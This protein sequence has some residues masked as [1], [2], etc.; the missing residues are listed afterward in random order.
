MKLQS[1]RFAELGFAHGFSL[2][3]GGVSRGPFDS[4]NLGRSV[5]DEEEAVLENLGRYADAVGYDPADLF[6][7][8]QVHG[9]EVVRVTDE[10]GRRDVRTIEADALVTRDPRL[11]I[12]VR[13][14]DCVPVLFGD[15]KSGVVGAA[16]AGWRGVVGGVLP[17]TIAAMQ[18]L[19]AEPGRLVAVIGPHIRVERFEIG[20]EV[21]EA[22]A[23]VSPERDPI[24]RSRE[25][26]HASLALAIRAQLEA[27]GVHAARIED[28]GGCS[29]DDAERFYS[30]RRDHGR[31]GRHLAVIVGP[32]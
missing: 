22:L 2:R 20:D 18:E 8:T 21:A 24:D 12:G 32:G 15:P 26:P 7:V 4:L 19:G 30:H 11:A 10:D 9:A 6:E 31:T 16:H 3:T 13:V 25:K 23:K 27:A 1:G 29:F 17:A 28:V 14:A 5:G